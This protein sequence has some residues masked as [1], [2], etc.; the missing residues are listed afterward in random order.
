MKTTIKKLIVLCSLLVWCVSPLSAAPDV[1]GD[2]LDSNQ[3]LLGI[4]ASVLQL[5]KKGAVGIPYLSSRDVSSMRGQY[6]QIPYYAKDTSDKSEVNAFNVNLGVDLRYGIL[7]YLEVFANAN[8]YYQAS[9]PN[10]NSN[11]N[12]M[13]HNVNFTNASIGLMA[14]LYKG[15]RFHFT[16]GDNSDVVSNTL[17]NNSDTSMSYFKGHTFFLNLVSSLAGEH[18]QYNGAVHLYYRLNLTQKYKDFSL[19]NGDEI[20]VKALWQFSN[21]NHLGF[22]GTNV[23]LYTQSDEINGVK[24]VNGKNYGVGLGFTTGFK[25]DIT[26]HFGLKFSAD[27]MSYAMD[28]NS[29]YW[30]LGL[31][32]YFK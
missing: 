3:F 8:G 28:R 18:S 7:G 23:V 6:I 15:E 31:G 27:I 17:F 32:I 2:V 11:D 13:L 5:G 25:K 1:E 30:G 19:R 10:R 9:F 24:L 12:D 21:K 20:G 14:T 29:F 22:I 4:N 16:I 26:E